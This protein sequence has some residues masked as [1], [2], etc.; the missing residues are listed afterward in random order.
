[1]FGKRKKKVKI[2]KG[3]L[4]RGKAS[5]TATLGSAGPPAAVAPTTEYSVFQN[6][7][8][9]ARNLLEIHRMAHGTQARPPCFLSDAHRAAVVLAVSALDAF[10]RTFVI[11][12]IVY[13]VANPSDSIP[14]KLR[15]MIKEY[16]DPDSILDAAR[17]G[18]FSSRVEKALRERFDDQSFQG[19]K[20]ITEAMQLIGHDDVFAT[21]AV[22]ASVNEKKLKGCI[23]KFT[24]RR[25]IIAHCGD[26]DLNQTPPEENK[27]VKKDVL[28]CIKTVELVA[29]EINKLR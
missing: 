12:K 13:K 26:Y 27:I 9:R 3:K 8:N 24:K 10:V 20:K 14:K 29:K 7:I 4:K 21:I 11:G 17:Q 2:T 28:E 16:L 1:L 6:S 22:S 25:H 15:E 5:A 23:G 18:D 19:I